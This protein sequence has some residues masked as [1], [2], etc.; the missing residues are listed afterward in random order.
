[1]KRR[2]F[3]QLAGLTCLGGTAMIG[4]MESCATS[5]YVNGTL[6][7]NI[8][9]VKKSDFIT[10]KND[11]PVNRNFVLIKHDSFPF[12]IC[13]YKLSENEYTALYLECTHQG[14]ELNAYQSQMVCPCH[15]SEFDTKGNVIGGPADYPLKQF[16]INTDDTNIYVKII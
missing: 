13:I 14:C 11:K 7:N 8:L 3:I 4:L 1:M 16:E 5:Q 2:N 9:Q 15:G 6:K 12:P 10:I